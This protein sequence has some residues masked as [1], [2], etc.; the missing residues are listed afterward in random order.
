MP[1]SSS[2]LETQLTYS[3]MI[4]FSKLFNKAGNINDI[5]FSG[6]CAG[7]DVSSTCSDRF[8]RPILN[9][10]YLA[11][12]NYPGKY[13]MDVECY[14]NVA[15]YKWQRLRLTMLDF[16]L[17]V[18]RSGRCFDVVSIRINEDQL[19]FHDCGALGKQILDL[20]SSEATIILKTGRTSIMQ[21]GFVI[22][23]EGFKSGLCYRSTYLTLFMNQ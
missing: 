21:R 18:K 13:F 8:S 16:E 4:T 6:L 14:W 12:P 5:L 10:G 9:R 19:V 11:S 22:H 2:L 17:D 7:S 23:F 3:S 1:Q 15:V 20:D